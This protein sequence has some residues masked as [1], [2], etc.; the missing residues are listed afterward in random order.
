MSIRSHIPNA[1]T[2]INV[3]SGF[4]AIYLLYSGLLWGVI[5]CIAL[6]LTADVLDGWAARKLGVAGPLG[7]QLDSL[8]DMVSFGVLPGSIMIFLMGWEGPGLEKLLGLASGILIT[9]S[10]FWRLAKFNLDTRQSKGFLGLPTPA[11]TL[12]VAGLLIA[13]IWTPH[14]ESAII[15]SAPSLTMQSFFLAWIMQAEIPM[16]G[17]KDA[18]ERKG[19]LFTMGIVILAGSILA[20][21]IAPYLL[22][23]QALLLYICTASVFHFFHINKKP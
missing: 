1:L 3:A 15:F 19:L 18:G 23:W 5:C 8:A 21:I 13:Q 14:Q 9:T 17:F 16:P 10:A 2:T 12:Y 20:M 6:S 4:L 11:M 22:L 7:V